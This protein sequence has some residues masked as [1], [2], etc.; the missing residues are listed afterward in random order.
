MTTYEVSFLVDRLYTELEKKEQFQNK[1]KLSLVRPD[2]IYANRKTFIRNYKEICNRLRRKSEDVQKFFNDELCAKTSIDSKGMLI[3]SGRF[4][5]NG[6]QNIVSNYIKMYVL[7]KECNASDTNLI[8]ENRIL[9]LDCK[10]C[11][12]K[13]A[14]N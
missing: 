10:K 14:I 1:S 4:R 6:I 7:C 8:K 11:L 5:Q 12:S 9:F 2:V 3:I 13:K